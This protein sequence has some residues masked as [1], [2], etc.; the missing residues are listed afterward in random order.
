M[1]VQQGSTTSRGAS[2][3]GRLVLLFVAVA[4]GMWFTSHD[5]LLTLTAAVVATVGMAIAQRF[6]PRSRGLS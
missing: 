2:A 6:A 4:S 5:L 1:D 3:G